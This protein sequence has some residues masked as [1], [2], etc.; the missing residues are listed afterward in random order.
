MENRI[1]FHW[2]ICQERCYKYI[3]G[4]TKCHLLTALLLEWIRIQVFLLMSSLKCAFPR[5]L[6]V[7]KQVFL[8]YIPFFSL[9]CIKAVT[10]HRIKSLKKSIRVQK[11][12]HSQKKCS[13]YLSSTFS[14]EASFWWNGE[15][16]RWG[17]RKKMAKAQ[18]NATVNC[19]GRQV[20]AR[21]KLKHTA[22]LQHSCSLG[23]HLLREPWHW[24]E[25]RGGREGHG[26][27]MN[28]KKTKGVWMGSETLQ[29]YAKNLYRRYWVHMASDVSAPYKK[30]TSLLDDGHK[31]KT[32]ITISAC[33]CFGTM[34]EI[35][36]IHHWLIKL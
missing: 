11:Q 27:E 33:V 3:S 10:Q 19:I 30:I 8:T 28:Q 29:E 32:V 5:R 24:A 26:R 35:M 16:R 17:G 7:V 18:S 21:K 4:K 15:R 13:L 22:L 31:L 20:R 23:R 14:E 12:T 34:A 1:S 9:L 25:N 6:T 2:L 36:V